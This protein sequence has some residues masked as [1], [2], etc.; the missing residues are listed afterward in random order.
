M[1]VRIN[2]FAVVRIFLLRNLFYELHNY[3]MGDYRNR[4]TRRQACPPPRPQAP[5]S[6]CVEP[7]VRS[8]HFEQRQ[9]LP[10]FPSSITT[11]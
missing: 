3:C 8:P 1:L 2:R 6:G 5:T 10:G 11:R 7:P 9:C 4:Y